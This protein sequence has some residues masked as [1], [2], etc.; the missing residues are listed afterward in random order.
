MYLDKRTKNCELKIFRL[1]TMLFVCRLVCYQKLVWFK[2][3]NMK[4]KRSYVLFYIYPPRP[5]V[6]LN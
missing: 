3:K 6:S 5:G 2:N 1:L 4:E